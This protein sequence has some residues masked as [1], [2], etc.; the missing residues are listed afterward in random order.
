MPARP[1]L[2][3]ETAPAT[4]PLQACDEQSTW[5]PQTAVM[6]PVAQPP[7]PAVPYA[8]PAPAEPAW[9]PGPGGPGQWG[10]VGV[11]PD[12]A[13]EPASHGGVVAC[14]GLLLV[15]LGAWAPSWVCSLLVVLTVAAGTV[16]RASQALRWRR[17]QRGQA[18]GETWLGHG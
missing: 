4:A 1:A 13:R 7:Q 18:L 8:Q 6:A 12:W 14:F 16:G 9:E 17:L 10:G 11:L 3:G 5:Q 15:A 2:Q